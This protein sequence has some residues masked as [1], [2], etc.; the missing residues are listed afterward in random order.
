M[1]KYNIWFFSSLLISTVV[2]LPIITVFLSFLSETSDYYILLKDTFLFE[3]IFN[4]LFILFFVVLITFF[5]GVLSAYFVSFY[6]FPFSNFFSWSLILAFAVPGYIYAF[7]IIAFFENYG[8]AFSML[9]YF[10]GESNYNLIIPKIDGIFGAILAI[11]FSLFPYVY[12][13][14]RASFHFQSNNYIEVGKNLGLSSKE[15]FF[16][17]I[18]PSARPAIFAG[19]ALVS[20]ECLSDFGTVSFFSVNTLTTGI[21]NS[22]LS[23]DDLNTANQIS[24]I[25]LL[26]I[27]FLLSVEIYSRKEARYHQPGSGFKP[28]TKIKLSGKKSFLPFIFCSLIIFISFLFPVSQMIYWTIKFPKYF[29]DINVINMNINTLLLVL[30]AS[31]S[32]VI[33]SL[34]INYGNRISKSK[35]LTYLTNFSISGYAIPGVI[36]AVSFITLFSNV[37]D[38]L[39]EN[40]GFKSSKGIFIG[41]ILGLIIAYFIR[42]FSLSF[43]GIKS[44]YE[45]INN[46]IDDSAYLLGYSKVKTFLKIHVPY[47]KTNVIL[48]MLLISLEVI[49]ELPI[50][51][52]LRPFNFETFATQAYIYAS[53]DLLEAAAL[54]SLFLIFWSTILILISSKYI[55]SKKN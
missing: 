50:T 2:A 1:T 28:I 7:S 26:F 8:T 39:S 51:L 16:K 44:S 53:Q 55:L 27:L 20:M 29:Q 42:F 40:L 33:I 36:L 23:Y 24:F 35:I 9:T 6:E 4:S 31:I 17:I 47:L 54:P 21:Y 22:W 5:L 25:L 46:S 10:F 32:I 48:I 14:T 19:L 34:F 49:K 43:N 12:V 11:S 41:S 15:S 38:F 18:L 30:L 3:Y 37:S 13:L 45:K 52:I